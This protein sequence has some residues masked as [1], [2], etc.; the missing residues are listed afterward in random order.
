MCQRQL[1]SLLD[2]LDLVLKAADVCV[3]LERRLLN[4]S[5]REYSSAK[6][7]ALMRLPSQHGVQPSPSSLY[8]RA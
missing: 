5:Q 6:A 1:D 2:L 8:G 7:A 3:R 4:L